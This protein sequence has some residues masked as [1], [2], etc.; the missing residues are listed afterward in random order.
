MPRSLNM[1][2]KRERSPSTMYCAMGRFPRRTVTSFTEH[3]GLRGR[4]AQ[5][6]LKTL[7]V[8]RTKLDWCAP[9]TLPLETMDRGELLQ[10]EIL[11]HVEQT[12]RLNNRLA[13]RKLG[14]SVKLAHVTLR[15]MVA[16]GLLHVKKA[17]ARRWDY[18]LT[19]AG[20]AEKTRLT[21]E[22]LEFSFQFYHEARKRSAQ[23]CR[24]LSERGMT[25]VAFLGA[26][27][28][29]EIT[30]LGVIE[31]KLQLTAVY[32]SSRSGQVFLSVPVRPFSEISRCPADAIIVC[33]YDKQHPMTPRF[34]PEGIRPNSKMHWVFA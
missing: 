29:A 30:Y 3:A 31:W 23:L 5:R 6:E 24:S 17:H 32:D 25:T 12:P 15:K 28:L 22:F 8:S 21:Y 2:S 4:T 16:K 11:R 13:A 20:I 19:P 7:S 18:F 10:L 1:G 34:V 27:E 33:L 9:V 14:V 26:G